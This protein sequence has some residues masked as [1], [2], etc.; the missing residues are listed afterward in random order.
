VSTTAPLNTAETGLDYFGARYFSGAQGRF[1]SPDPTF[2]TE[3]RIGDP[4]QWN[5]Y[6]YTR[7]NPLKYI[8]PDG[9][10]LR[11]AVTNLVVGQ[12]YVNRLPGGRSVPG[13]V[14][15]A[16][17]LYRLTVENDSGTTAAFSV[18][19][20]TN[21]TGPIEGTRGLYGSDQEAPPG[22][23][24]GDVRRDG[25]RGF[26]IQL[27]DKPGESTI[28]APDGTVRKNV[29][30][31]VGPGCSQ[32]CM[33]LPGG[34][35]GRDAFGNTIDKMLREDAANGNGTAIQVTVQDRNR[36]SAAEAR[37]REEELRKKREEENR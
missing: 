8:D 19:R 35:A 16:A 22:T 14:S 20:D 36:A 37:K 2:T 26:R 25:D 27:S 6:S 23:Y 29:Q 9:R 21:F 5:L 1:T 7:N 33:L 18:T 32:G 28:M 4:Q 34:R 15:Q 3:E 24:V 12:S 13:Q 17:P 30:I 10:D 31:H 11:L